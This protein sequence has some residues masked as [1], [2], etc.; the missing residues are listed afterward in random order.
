MIEE[1]NSTVDMTGEA[2]AEE[3]GPSQPKRMC[4]LRIEVLFDVISEIITDSTN[5]TPATTSVVEMFLSESLL[6]YRI[7]IPYTWWCQNQKRFSI[8]STLAQHYLCPLAK[9]IPSKQ[10]FSAAGNVHDDIRKKLAY[11]RLFHPKQF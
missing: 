7:G 9:S 4:P 3:P 11:F 5:D 10:L 1:M 6:D 2:K 8:L